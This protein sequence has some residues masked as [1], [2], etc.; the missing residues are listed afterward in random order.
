MPPIRSAIIGTGYIASFHARAIR[1]V[2][3]VELVSVC[4]ANLSS[5]QGFAADWGVPAAFDSLESMLRDQPVDAVHVL[6]PPDQHYAVASAALRS[7]VHVFLEK[8]MCISTD[9]ADDLLKMVFDGGP[10]LGVNHN[11]LFSGAYQRLRKIVHSGTIGPLDHVAFNHFFELPQIWFGPFDSWMLRAPRNAIL[12]IGP[13][14][15]SALLDLVGHPNDLSAIADRDVILPGGARVF[16]RWRINTTVGRTAVDININL[17]PG[18][19]QRTINARGQNGSAVVD[20]D[21]N[22]CALDR[23]TSLG[24]DLD[25]YSRSRSLAHQIHSQARATVADYL[26]STLKLRHRG[27][28]YQATFLDSVESFYTCLATNRPLDS[29][30]D[31]ETGRDVIKWCN[32][33]V[34]AAGVAEVNPLSRPRRKALAAQPTVLVFGGAGFIGRELVHQLLASE[35]CVRAVV[36]RSGSVL[37]EIDSE[38]LEII[39]GDMRSE[40]NLRSLMKGIDFV[41]HLARADA[42]TWA[43]YL[44]RD[45]EP[46]RLIAEASLEARVK[47]L[48]YTSTIA[49]YF[50]GANGGSITEKTSLDHAIAQRDYYSRAKATAEAT[51]MEM[52]RTKQLPVVIFRPGIVIGQ[53]GTPF[54]WGVGMWTTEALCEVWGDGKN[55]LPF[56]L[57]HDVAAA[58]MR[59]IQVAGI[60]GRTY[61]LVDLPLLTARDYLEELQRHSSMT[62]DVRYR[63]IFQFYLT[64]LTKWLVKLLVRHPDRRRIPS[65]RDWESRTHKALFDCSRARAELNWTPASDRQRLIDEGIGGSLRAWLKADGEFMKA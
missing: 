13:H 11:F 48:I 55:K 23:R 34:Q 27:A 10:K 25:R 36:H 51:L 43:D 50:T 9:Q 63:S 1:G 26:L 24:L 21:A 12:E 2:K 39:R 42:K 61:N 3:G 30:L 52:H 28:P 6:V 7:G 37:E 14:L 33:I 60:E 56:V 41:F 17:G 32:K 54:H 18:F 29:R 64:D 65:Y 22:T 58:L 15:I 38:R 4:D 44:Q 49:S 31:S 59:G 46:T 16:R 40:K 53:H 20:F 47:R 5:A 19:S 8:P 57:V 35:Y 62:V 45:L